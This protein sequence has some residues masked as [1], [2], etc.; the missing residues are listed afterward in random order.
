MAPSSA[1]PWKRQPLR[2][3][4]GKLLEVLSPF[5]LNCV[6]HLVYTAIGD[7]ISGAISTT[8]RTQI[9]VRRRFQFSSSLKRMSTVSSLPDGKTMVAVKGAPEAIK[10]MLGMIPEG[11]DEIYKHFTRRGSRV[12]ALGSKTMGSLS[13]EKVSVALNITFHLVFSLFSRYGNYPGSRSKASLPSRDSSSFTALSRPTLLILSECWRIP[14]IV[15]VVMYFHGRQINDLS[16]CVMITGDNPL[17]AIHVAHEVEIVDRDVLILD[18][19]D[20]K[21]SQPGAL[22]PYMLVMILTSK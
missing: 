2:L 22:V 5:H 8:H 3:L 10:L 19:D 18:V 21:S 6:I 16:Q 12:L 14:P 17:T 4:I 20:V 13:V 11:Y 15:C 9:V 7:V 1:I